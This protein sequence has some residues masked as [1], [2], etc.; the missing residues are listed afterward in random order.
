MRGLLMTALGGVAALT[1]LAAG[2][3]SAP[4][5]VPARASAGKDAPKRPNVLFIYMDDHAAQTI[6]AYGSRF[7][8]TPNIDSLASEGMLFRNAFC[9][10]SICAP[11]RAVVLT[12]KHSHLNGVP[13][14][15]STFDGTQ[16]TFPK[17]LQAAGYRTAMIGKW[18]LRS[19]PTGFDHFEVLRGQGPYYNPVLLTPDG[20]ERHRGY[21]TEVITERALAFLEEAAGGEEPWLLMY[22]HKAPHRNWQPGPNEVGLFDDVEFPEPPTLFDDYATRNPGAA[23]QEM[24]IATHLRD[25][26]D[27]KLAPPPGLDEEQLATWKAAYDPRNEA[28]FADPP[29]GDARTRWNYQRYT[30]DYMRCIH[31]VDRQVGR[32]LEA[33]ERLGLEDDTLVIYTSDQGFYLGEHGWYDKRWMYEESLR[34]PLIARWP[35]VI[36]PGTEST[37]LVQNLDFAATFLELAGVPEAMSTQGQSL[38]P[39]LEGRT[40]LTWRKD[41]YYRYYEVGEHAVPPHYGV[42]TETHKLIHFPDT[43]FTELFDLTQD[44]LEVRSVADDPEHEALRGRLEGRLRELAEEVGDQLPPEEP[45]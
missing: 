38:V 44:P 39:L 34:F 12:G 36:A 19:T 17:A 32:V 40:P 24:S 41:L 5:G 7:G 9:T 4:E 43:G 35:G 18:H 30:K 2:P 20:Q 1:A 14:N 25:E 21:T 8:P 37:A 3:A 11:A 33:L 42:R 10:N 13:D 15:G 26:Y 29:E 28:F 45:N 31:G 23:S 22:Q 16:E 27:L 6:G